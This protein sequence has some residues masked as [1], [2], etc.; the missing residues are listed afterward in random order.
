MPVIHKHSTLLSTALFLNGSMSKPAV[1]I[2][3][4]LLFLYIQISN[5]FNFHS[6]WYRL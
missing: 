3:F 6:G 2:L 4:W 5:L 1:F